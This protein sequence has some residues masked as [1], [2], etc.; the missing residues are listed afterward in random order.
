MNE[1][2]RRECEARFVLAMPTKEDR[3]AYIKLV[4]ARRGL[5]SSKQ[6]KEDIM[7]EWKKIKD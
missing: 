1:H 5:I 3:A 4:R 2:H 7:R 6:L